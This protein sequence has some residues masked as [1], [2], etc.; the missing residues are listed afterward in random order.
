MYARRLRNSSL[1][2]RDY[3]TD[4]R[5][6]AVVETLRYARNGAPSVAVGATRYCPDWTKLASDASRAAWAGPDATL[7]W[8]AIGIPAGSVRDACT[9]ANGTRETST[10]VALRGIRHRCRSRFVSR[11]VRPSLYVGERTPSHH[12]DRM[13]QQSLK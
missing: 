6:Y 7:P 12:D 1:F 11:C 5:S 2:R 9:G 10:M 13:I 3:I 4:V 8:R